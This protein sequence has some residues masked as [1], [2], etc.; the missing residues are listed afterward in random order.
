AEALGPLLRRVRFETGCSILMIEHDMPLI[1]GIADELIA[2]A[3]GRVVTRGTADEVL[4]DD[5]VIESFLGTS[6]AAVQRSGV[7][8]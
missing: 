6:E 2:M 5:R 1:S 7:R 4:N 3:E 8:A